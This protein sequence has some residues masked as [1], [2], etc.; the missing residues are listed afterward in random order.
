MS[1]VACGALV[2]FTP[3]VLKTAGS[4]NQQQSSRA[5]IIMML[6]T[7]LTALMIHTEQ[8]VVLHPRCTFPWRVPPPRN[9]Y[10]IQSVLWAVTGVGTI[11]V[12]GRAA[13][14]APHR[15]AAVT[16]SHTLAV[17]FAFIASMQSTAVALAVWL[18]LAVAAFVHFATFLVQVLWHCGRAPRLCRPLVW[19]MGPIL[20]AL[21]CAIPCAV[22]LFSTGLLPSGMEVVL[23]PFLNMSVINIFAVLFVTLSY[24]ERE[25]CLAEE[26]RIMEMERRTC[27]KAKQSKLQMMKYV[28]RVRCLW[29]SLV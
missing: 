2:A 16:V 9:E 24:L 8:T 21:W 11:A 14:Q 29:S 19:I 15:V 26:L 4:L 27:E 28:L 22:I 13:D 10:P 25:G 20:L 17:V 6:Q 7:M 5:L 1:G 18:T 23:W 3:L 12:M